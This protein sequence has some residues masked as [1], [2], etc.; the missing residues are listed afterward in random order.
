MPGWVLAPVYEEWLATLKAEAC[1]HERD[2]GVGDLLTKP[3][4]PRKGMGHFH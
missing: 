1:E 2:T 3:I 4:K